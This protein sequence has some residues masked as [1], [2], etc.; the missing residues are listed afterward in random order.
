MASGNRQL[1]VQ[2]DV[3]LVITQL[4]MDN[5]RK[6]GQEVENLAEEECHRMGTTFEKKL[7][8]AKARER[9]E[10]RRSARAR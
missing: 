8:E 3:K 4:A 2:P 7:A 1:Y 9:K 6:P 5:K 10:R